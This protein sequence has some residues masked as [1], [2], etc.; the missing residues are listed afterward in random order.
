MWQT[1]FP[2]YGGPN[3]ISSR[4]PER[5]LVVNG[6]QYQLLVGGWLMDY[7]NDEDWYDNLLEAHA[8]QNYTGINVPAADQLVAQA[9]VSLDPQTATALYQRAEQLYVNQVAWIVLDQ[10]YDT[11]LVNPRVVGYT[12]NM[13]GLIPTT[14]QLSAYISS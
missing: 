6:L 10:P 14:A 9:N 11:Y 12:E 2:S 13:A 8:E 7:P 5:E 1:A 3:G 4:P